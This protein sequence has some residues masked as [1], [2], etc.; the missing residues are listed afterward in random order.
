MDFYGNAVIASGASSPSNP[1]AVAGFDRA[2]T[3]GWKWVIADP[4]GASRRGRQVDPLIDQEL[5]RERLRHGARRRTSLTPYVR[6]TASA[7]STP[8]RLD[9]AIGQLDAALDLPTT[10]AVADIWTDAFLPP[11]EERRSDQLSGA[12]TGVAP[13]HRAS[14]G[15]ALRYGGDDGTLALEDCSLA[16][17]RGEFAAVVGPSGCGKST[18]LKLRHRPGPGRPPAR[19]RLDGRAIAGPQHGIGMAFQNPTLLPWRTTLD[20]VLLPLEVSQDQRRTFRAA[21]AQHV[22][23]ARALL[24][25]VGLAEFA[26]HAPYQLS[27][28]MQQR[29]NLCRALIHEPDLLLLDEPFARARRVHPRGAVGRAAGA[30]AAPALHGDPGDPRPARGGLPRRHRACRQQAPRPD[31][32]SRRV[33]LPRP[34]TLAMTFEPGFVDIVHELRDADQRGARGMS[35]AATRQAARPGS[36]L[37]LCSCCGSRPAGCSR[38]PE[39]ILPTPSASLAALWEYPARSGSTPSSPSG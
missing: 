32:P 33:D 2:V 16:V 15:V 12:R 38:C 7:A 25:T 30:V 27:G 4:T 19:P 24:R 1:E 26:G 21:Q 29:A 11:A 20:N 3:K 35:A 28:G 23:R 6:R 31:R 37:A 13:L 5:E 10:P 36:R 22:E 17:E 34:R 39:F 9:R 8:A 14:S 18:L